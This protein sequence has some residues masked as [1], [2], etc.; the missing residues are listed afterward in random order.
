MFTALIRPKLEWLFLIYSPILFKAAARN[1]YAEEHERLWNFHISVFAGTASQTISSEPEN[2][3]S[4]V[5]KLAPE[6]S[7][8][9]PSSQMARSYGDCDKT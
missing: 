4:A 1:N 5:K 7:D 6:R 2:K 9:I 3:D 8:L